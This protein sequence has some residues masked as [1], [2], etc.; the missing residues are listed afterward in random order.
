ME[1]Y[2]EISA[3]LANMRSNQDG[4]LIYGAANIAN[5]FFSTDF[6]ERVPSF[7]DQLEYH[8]AHKKIS[9]INVSTRERVFPKEPNGIKLERFVFDVFSHSEAF[10]VLHVD[11]ADEFAP[12]KNGSGAGV[13]CPETSRTAILNQAQRFITQAGGHYQDQSIEVEISPLLSYG[14][15]N[16]EKLNG[17]FIK[18]SCI[19]NSLDDVYSL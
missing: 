1:K 18:K 14:G 17:K 10:S 15:E 16:L 4:S 7:A 9:F 6:L 13:D 3:E 5:H 2:S 8:V 19:L 11:R 12:L